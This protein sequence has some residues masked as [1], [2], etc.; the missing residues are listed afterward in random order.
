[1]QLARK[2]HENEQEASPKIIHHNGEKFLV[3]DFH[4]RKDRSGQQDAA[5][6]KAMSK[7]QLAEHF[8]VTPRTLLNWFN[9]IEPQLEALGYHKHMKVL[10][11][12]LTRFVLGWFG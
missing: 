2:I 7:A 5:P 6:T 3:L 11:P 9:R 1:M 8:G 12:K 10:T 4:D